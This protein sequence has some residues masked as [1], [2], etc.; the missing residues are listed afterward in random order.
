MSLH[1][2]DKPV[3]YPSPVVDVFGQ[4]SRT[5]NE[6]PGERRDQPRAPRPQPVPP[7]N[8]PDNLFATTTLN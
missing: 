5:D 6:T 7:L 1:D 2:P 3:S 4:L 8:W